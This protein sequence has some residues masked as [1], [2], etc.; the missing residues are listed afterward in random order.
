[1]LQPSVGRKP[2]EQVWGGTEPVETGEG[3]G[4]DYEVANEEQAF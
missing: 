2:D 1:M 3:G 4:R